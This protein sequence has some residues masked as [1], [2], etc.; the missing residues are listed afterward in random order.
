[1]IDYRDIAQVAAKCLTEDGHEGGIYKLSGPELIS[2]S[3]IAEK[4]SSAVGRPI[5]F[6]DMPP[7]EFSDL[8]KSMGRPA[9]H[10]EEMT[11]SYVGMSKGVS[12][13]LTDDVKR[14]L[15]RPAT[16]FEKLAK[17]YAHLFR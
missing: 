15:G 1:M 2:C 5:K 6:N 17:D 7:A 16:P 14:I 13:V 11:T 8:L 3:D 10:A 4:L 12:A 9:W